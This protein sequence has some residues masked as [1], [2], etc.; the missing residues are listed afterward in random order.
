MKCFDIFNGDADGICALL[1]LRQI[2]PVD[3]ILVTGI[4]RDIK[5]LEKVHA[6]QGDKLTVLDVSLDKNKTALLRNLKN[7]AEVFYV[8]HHFCGEIPDHDQLTT[9]INLDANTC[10]SLLMNEHL[11]NQKFL[12]AITGAF[13]DNLKV[14]AENLSRQHQLSDVEMAQ[15]NSLGIYL[16][17]NGYGADIDDLHFLPEQLYKKLLPYQTPFDFIQDK[18]SVFE[19]L[20]SAYKEDNAL[21]AHVKAE[22]Q[23]DN[24]AVFIFPDEA[25]ARRISGIYSN[26]LVNQFPDRAHAVLTHNKQDG[27]LISV[28]A[29][30]NNKTGADDLCRQFPGGG[31]RKAAA[32]IN[33]IEKSNLDLFIN[34]FSEQFK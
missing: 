8:D 23:T 25:W 29:P 13:G 22:Y 20:E 7:G 9:L 14:S 26:D 33:H 16:N 32:G 3:S 12:W 5:L 11:E 2:N 21:V 30:L 28:R 18:S 6:E 19:Q 31:G 17:Y 1:Q 24:I 4:K 10:T 34:K 15:L 27:Y